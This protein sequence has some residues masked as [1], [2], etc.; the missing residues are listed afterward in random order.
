MAATR[1]RI[2]RTEVRCGAAGTFTTGFYV[3][4]FGALPSGWWGTDTL[5]AMSVQTES[6]LRE[7]VH[8]AARRAPGGARE[9]GTLTT[10][11]RDRALH[12]AADAVLATR[13]SWPPAHRI[14]R[15]PGRAARPRRCWTGWRSTRSGSTGS[16]PACVR[17]R[18]FPTRS[19]YCADAPCPTVC[20]CDS[21][22]CP[23]VW[24]ASST[25]AGPTS[26]STPSG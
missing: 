3:S 1:N 16:P 25:R 4:P 21:S 22:G 10:A 5:G 26:P 11:V 14:S 19:G 17:S 7:A 8:G 23:S 6:D 20:R 13:R 12:A 15:S 9:L 24:S 2:R 18:A